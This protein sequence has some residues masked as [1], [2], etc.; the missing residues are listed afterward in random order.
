MT[1]L[2]DAGS[3]SKWGLR[4][5]LVQSPLHSAAELASKQKSLGCPFL[6]CCIHQDHAHQARPRGVAQTVG[7]QSHS[8][9]CSRGSCYTDNQLTRQPASS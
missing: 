3:L 9:D 4:D 1:E 6:T 8:V 7:E 5:K 2:R